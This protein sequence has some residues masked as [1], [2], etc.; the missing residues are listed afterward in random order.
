[1]NADTI[2]KNITRQ[3]LLPLFYHPDIEIC[4]NILKSLYKSGV[5]VVEYTNRGEKALETYKKLILWKKENLQDFKLGV[6]TIKDQKTAEDF[7]RAGAD[8]LVSPGYDDEVAEIAKAQNTLWIP[9]CMTPTEVIRAENKGFKIVKIFPGNVLTPQF[10]K[11]MKSV[12]PNVLIMPTGG[13]T[14]EKK[15][16]KEWFNAGVDA[17]GMG[18]QLI[19]KDLLENGNYNEIGTLTKETIR[20]IRVLRKNY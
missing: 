8:F 1:M 20:L 14:P 11:A 5:R 7:I 6:G 4:K 13:V 17:V 10:I 2:I 15:N 12:C 19:R 3:G 9:G 16:L 18:S